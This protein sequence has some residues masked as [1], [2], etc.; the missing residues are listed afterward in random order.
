MTRRSALVDTRVIYCGD[1]LEQLAQAPRRLRRPDLHRPAVQLQPQ[2]RSLLGRDQGEAR[3]RGPP[4]QSPRPTSTTCAR[5]AS[6][7]PA[8]SRRPAASTTTATGTPRHYVKVMLD[9][10]FGENNFQNEIVWK[11]TTR[12]QRREAALRPRPRHRSSIYAGGEELHVAITQY[13]PYSEAYLESTLPTR[14]G[15]GRAPVRLTRLTANQP[16]ATDGAANGP[17]PTVRSATRHH[18]TN[19]RILARK[20]GA[21]STQGRLIY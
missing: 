15:R 21:S 7:S 12:T 4:R 10:I 2:L 17:D 18:A 19:W 9:Q 13:T 11:R 20:H 16:G 14:R 3:L 5:A 8:S 1:N 6:N